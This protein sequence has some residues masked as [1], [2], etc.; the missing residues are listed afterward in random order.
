MASEKLSAASSSRHRVRNPPQTLPPGTR[1]GAYLVGKVLRLECIGITYRARHVEH[2][3]DVAVREYLPVHLA[4]RRSDLT[5]H[6]R[7]TQQVDDFLW[8][9]DRFLAE[10]AALATLADTPGVVTVSD[11][12][13]ANGTAYM[14]IAPV[15]RETLATRLS[16]VDRLPREAIGCLLPPL[17]DALER[18][19]AKG[20]LHLDIKP[21][22]IALDDRGQPTLFDFGAARAAIADRM[23]TTGAIHTPGYA[24]IEQFTRGPV[25]PFTD[26]YALAATLHQCITGAA[27]PSADARQTERLPP[28]PRNIAKEY[29][30]SLLAGIEAGL[31]LSA[32][33]R[34]D[35]IAAWRSLLAPD[36]PT[37]VPRH[38]PTVTVAPVLEPARAATVVAELPP[39]ALTPRHV[40]PQAPARTV[41]VDARGAGPPS[42]AMPGRGAGGRDRWKIALSATVAAALIPAGVAGYYATLPPGPARQPAGVLAVADGIREQ[43]ASDAVR[44]VAADVEAR[45]QAQAQAEARRR[46][47]SEAQVRRQA[48]QA[49]RQAAETAAAEAAYR[50]MALEDARAEA[51]AARQAAEAD[52]RRRAE[53][54]AEKARTG[55]EARKQAPAIEAALELSERDKRRVQVALTSLGHDT[56]GADG[57]FGNRTRAMIGAWQQARGEADTGYLTAPELALLWLQAAPALARYERQLALEAQRRQEAQKRLADPPA[58]TPDN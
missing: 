8:G 21:A 53:K 31:V 44:Q 3:S 15:P 43:P 55:A 52:D 50:R 30:G 9:C 46:A 47:A 26:I 42:R 41:A 35:S 48:E 23:P 10:A 45:A 28:L 5:V 1:V 7:S 17:L 33:H 32:A 39:A 40:D 12:L 56:Y 54:D 38:A 14:V 4:A 49:A 29:E 22:N 36:A 51:L 2:G 58:P 18:A 27:P 16:R 34:P 37:A 25:G 57:R 19:H 20:I 6:P 11:Y 24:A 13:S